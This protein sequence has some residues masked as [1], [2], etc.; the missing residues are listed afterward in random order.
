MR[1]AN[2]YAFLGARVREERTKAGLTVEELAEN[3]SISPS[4]LAYIE[5]GKKKASL[6]TVHKLAGGLGMPVEKL[7]SNAPRRPTPPKGEAI[8]R[9]NLLLREKTEA[10]RRWIVDVVRSL[11]KRN[12]KSNTNR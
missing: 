6:E 7:L 8:T 3:A 2:I 10:E 1:D 4:F 12:R 5:R 11:S 9:H